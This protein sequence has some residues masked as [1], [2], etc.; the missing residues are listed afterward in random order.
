M[1]WKSSTLRMSSLDP[2]TLRVTK[3][4]N[5]LPPLVIILGPTAVGKT[6]ITIQLAE[7]LNGE[8]VSADS[9]LFYRGMDI[10]TAK[11]SLAERQCVPH[12]LIDVADPDQTWSLA[13]FQRQA[14]LAIAGILSRDRLPFLVG[15]TGQYIRAVIQGWD[16]P[17]VQPNPRLRTILEQWTTRITQ[18]GLHS[19]LA[20][21]DPLAAAQIDPRNQR[22]TIRALE[23]I[24]STGQRFSEQRLSGL[25][26]YDC[27]LLG[28][29]RSRPELYARIDARIDAM[30]AGGLVDEVQGLLRQGYPPTLPNLSAIGYREIIAYLQG[31]TSL[32]EAIMLIKRATRVFVRRQANWFKT[33]DPTI[34]WFYPESQTVE[35][36]IL[37]ITSWL[38]RQ[39]S[40]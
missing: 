22:R 34:Y 16:V 8:I 7:R 40:P 4:P 12:H 38:S 26:L 29:T 18:A 14:R 2:K 27:L 24:L 17:K 39:Q 35:E 6:E 5:H 15:G 20:S 11:P 21:L 36:M 3:V 37:L 1:N 13:L 9:R 31:K 10:G 28:L 19:R 33:N 23:V 32:E 25:L 30:L